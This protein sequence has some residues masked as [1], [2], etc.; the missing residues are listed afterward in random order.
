MNYFDY[1][2]M[3]GKEDTKE[4]FIDYLIEILGYTEQEAETMTSTY[5]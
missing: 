1:L 5:F 4:S 2:R 3:T